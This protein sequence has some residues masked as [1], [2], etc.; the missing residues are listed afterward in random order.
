MPELIRRRDGAKTTEGGFSEI[1][2]R[3]T[4]AL[5]RATINWFKG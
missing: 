3:V 5:N 2:Q 4:I 1:Y